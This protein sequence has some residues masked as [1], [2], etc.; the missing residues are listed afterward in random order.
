MTGVAVKKKKKDINTRLNFWDPDQI[1]C[2]EEMSVLDSC[3]PRSD[4]SS[5]KHTQNGI[6]K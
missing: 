6:Y 1:I 2:Y 5:A 3:G 4:S